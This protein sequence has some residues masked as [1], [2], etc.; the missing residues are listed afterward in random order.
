MLRTILGKDGNTELTNA[1][2][3]FEGRAK[4]INQHFKE[5]EYQP[6][7]CGYM[8]LHKWKK[9]T[10]LGKGQKR[11]ED[12]M[13]EIEARR[14]RYLDHDAYTILQNGSANPIK[15]YWLQQPND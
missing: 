5:K 14:D 9:N 1:K 12:E 3:L 8:R 11:S 6:I 4:K 10:V 13:A 7:T 2:R 15:D